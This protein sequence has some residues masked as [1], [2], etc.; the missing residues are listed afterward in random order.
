MKHFANKRVRHIKDIGNFSYYKRV[1]RT[2]D[3]C[4]YKSI[5]F[6]ATHVKDYLKNLKDRDMYHNYV[7]TS[8]SMQYNR[9]YYH[10]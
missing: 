9:Y 5:Y 10:K 1:F 4:D 7:V 2:Y 8:T 6:K 3:V